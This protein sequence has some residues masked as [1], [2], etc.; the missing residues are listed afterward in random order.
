MLRALLVCCAAL[1]GCDG[2]SRDIGTSASGTLST[3]VAARTVTSGTTTTLA[4][5]DAQVLVPA[6]PGADSQGH[7]RESVGIETLGGAFTVVLEAGCAV[8]CARTE[9]FSTASDDQ[10]SLELHLL[11][12]S[13]ARAADATSMGR[14]RILG[15]PPSMRGLPRIEVT[16]M[17]SSEGTFVQVRNLNGARVRLEGPAGGQTSR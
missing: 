8:P 2:A 5:P 9:V 12:G 1:F 15:I 3:P 14:V 10:P 6:E 7:L 11:R 16:F 4:P 17:A 13:A